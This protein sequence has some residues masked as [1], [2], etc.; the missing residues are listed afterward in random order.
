MNKIERK[1]KVELVEA[2]KPIHLRQIAVAMAEKI[3]KEGAKHD[4]RAE[5]YATAKRTR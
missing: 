4:R 1:I 3:K 5:V 2:N